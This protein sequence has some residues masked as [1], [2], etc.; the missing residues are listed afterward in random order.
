MFWNRETQPCFWRGF[1]SS[2]KQSVIVVWKGSH[3]YT[4]FCDKGVQKNDEL[5]AL[6]PVCFMN[7]HEEWKIKTEQ[8]K[9][10]M[11]ENVKISLSDL[12][13]H[14][15]RQKVRE[16]IRSYKDFTYVCDFVWALGL[17]F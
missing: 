13:G 4:A 14:G 1:S 9:Q 10:R 6:L 15:E 3:V 12:K 17:Y 7:W 2:D 11:S 16:N 8:L 5:S